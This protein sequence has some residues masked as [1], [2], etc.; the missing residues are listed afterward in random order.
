[1]ICSRLQAACKHPDLS[2]YTIQ[3]PPSEH[4]TAL[5]LQVCDAYQDLL[6]FEGQE[7]EE[8]L[9]RDRHARYLQAG[10]GQLPSGAMQISA[11]EAP[12]LVYI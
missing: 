12:N 6:E 3:Q 1:V 8:L 9:L 7:R 5:P 10:L 4:V 11:E 2:I